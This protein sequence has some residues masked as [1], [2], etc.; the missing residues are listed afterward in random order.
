[1]KKAKSLKRVRAGKK[2]SRKGKSFER[3]VSKILSEW[4]GEKNSFCR[5]PQSGGWNVVSDED[6]RARTRGDLVTPKDFPFVISCKKVESFEFHTILSE[7]NIFHKWWNEIEEIAFDCG[8]R[9]MLI[10]SRNRWKIFV[11]VLY[12]DRC[13][14]NVNFDE[15]IIKFKDKKLSIFTLSDFVNKVLTDNIRMNYEEMLVVQ[16]DSQQG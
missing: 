2:A 1:V 12:E 16:D 13:K 9:P 11:V 8:K 7:K 4:W 14:M 10:F 3:E 5:V 15:M 6:L